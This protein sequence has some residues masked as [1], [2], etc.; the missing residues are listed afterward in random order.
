MT[1]SGGAV[2]W[3]TGGQ[4]GRHRRPAAGR[5]RRRRGGRHGRRPRGHRALQRRH[6]RRR[7]PRLLR[8]P[9]A[10]VARSTAA[11]PRPRRSPSTTF[12]EARRHADGL[13]HR[14]ELRA[15]GGGPG[16]PGL[17]G[18]GRSTDCGT[19]APRRP[20]CSRPSALARD[21]LRGRPDLPRPDRSTTPRASPSSPRRRRSSCPAARPRPSGSVF[22]NP[23]MARAY[24]SCAREGVDALYR[25]RLGARPR[26]RGP[27][28]PHTAP[29]VS[30]LPAAQIT[31]ATSP[32]TASLEQGPGPLALQGLGRLRHAGAE[33]AAASRSAEILNL[34]EAYDERTGT[35]TS[36][37]STTSS[38]CTGSPRPPRP[39]SPT[40][41][42]TSATCRGVP[43]T[44]LTSQAFADERACLFDPTKAQPRPIPFGYARRPLHRLRGGRADGAG[45]PHEGTVDD[46]PDG[47][48]PLGQ[49]RVAYTLTIEQTGG[50][51]I[52]VPGWGFLL[53]NELTDFNFVPLTAG[54]PDPNLPGPGKR[55]R[56][57]MSPTIVLDDGR[58]VPRRVG[59]PGW[60]H[61]HHVGGPDRSSATSTADLSTRSTP[62]PR[63]GCPRRNGVERGGRAGDRRR[64][65]RGGAEGPRPH[66]GLHPGDRRGDG[67][68]GARPREVQA[69][70]EPTRR[71]GGSAM[72]VRPDGRQP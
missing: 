60:R 56:S 57:S 44:E 20:C 61:D 3:S 42:A 32:P 71:G 41:T 59:S 22:R 50:S 53:N 38:T 46:A 12:T 49:R 34:I 13:Q 36:P 65:R 27:Q 54:V 67:N 55:P 40:A 70:A 66:A 58:L 5:Q 64:A 23:D 48:R 1:G 6:R 4:P 45:E 15:V 68:P 31:R 33:L 30:V 52:T 11:R 29:G 21:G 18:Q 72:V 19:P 43:V 35:P 8:R 9:Q 2:A 24:R 26:R 10:R 39:R 7:L 16:H 28:H 63:R 62:S 47:R 25:G 51:G 37:R 17:V 14:R 69:A